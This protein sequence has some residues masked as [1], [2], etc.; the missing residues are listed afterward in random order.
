MKNYVIRNST[1]G[2][3][4]VILLLGSP[5]HTLATSCEIRVF[6]L[7]QVDLVVDNADRDNRLLI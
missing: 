7:I 4:V 3:V 1:L 6:Q 2:T 5:E